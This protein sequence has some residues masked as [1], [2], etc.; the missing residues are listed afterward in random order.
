MSTINSVN[1]GGIDTQQTSQTSA[2][3]PQPKQEVVRKEQDPPARAPAA[4]SEM[5]V[6]SDADMR[7]LAAEMQSAIDNASKEPL[8]VELKPGEENGG[9]VIE[10]RTGNGDLVQKFPPEKVLNMRHKLDELSGMVVDE[11]T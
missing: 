1:N 2:A 3:A 6:D 8:N 5:R 10:I 9:F 4:P 11:M 7:K